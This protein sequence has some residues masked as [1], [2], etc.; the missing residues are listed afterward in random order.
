[1]FKEYTVQ[2][3]G[4]N[5]ESLVL[6]EKFLTSQI[7]RKL[8]NVIL[9]QRYQ[10]TAQEIVLSVCPPRSY[11][12]WFNINILYLFWQKLHLKCPV[13]MLWFLKRKSIHVNSSIC[14]TYIY[15]KQS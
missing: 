2:I 3:A 4:P 10:S 7:Q 14:L 15:A 13:Y 8:L 6:P 11:H 5:S 9:N 1:M 12:Y